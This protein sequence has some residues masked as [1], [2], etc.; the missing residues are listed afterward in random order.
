[1]NPDRPPRVSRDFSW[2]RR[3]ERRWERRDPL[4]LPPI[5]WG[6]PRLDRGLIYDRLNQQNGTWTSG[7]GP[8]TRG[9]SFYSQADLENSAVEPD[10]PI[11][12]PGRE[13]LVHL[14][15]PAVSTLPVVRQEAP[16]RPS[17]STRR[18]Y[19]WESPSAF[20][21]TSI[22]D[23]PRQSSALWT[24][25]GTPV[26]GGTGLTV[27]SRFP[28]TVGTA[29]GVHVDDR[30]RGAD[31]LLDLDDPAQEDTD[32][33]PDTTIPHHTRILGK[34]CTHPVSLP[35]CPRSTRTRFTCRP[36]LEAVWQEEEEEVSWTG[37]SG[38]T[39]TFRLKH[40]TWK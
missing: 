8:G 7:P 38:R 4:A 2:E 26:S 6:T 18:G 16:S 35:G 30:A 12:S 31:S 28:R 40:G 11:I 22:Y 32:Q 13:P 14:P 10:L 17:R 3:E 34:G 36:R 20:P 23:Q 1:M 15:N 27:P 25:T 19:W 5:S 39:F 37:S 33:P 9:S 21:H 29:V 24:D